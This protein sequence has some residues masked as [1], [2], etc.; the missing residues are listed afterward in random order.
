MNCLTCSSSMCGLIQWDFF[1][2]TTYTIFPPTHLPSGTSNLV[3]PKM[4]LVFQFPRVSCVLYS[5]F[6]V[7]VPS[8]PGSKPLTPLCAPLVSEAR[9]LPSLSYFQGTHPHHHRAWVQ[10]PSASPWACCNDLV[11]YHINLLSFPSNPSHTL[12]L[13]D[14]VLVFNLRI[15]LTL[16]QLQLADSSYLRCGPLNEILSRNSSMSIR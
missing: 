2:P 16:A 5:L 9:R 3:F 13:P 10:G 11:S 15:H 12:R 14:S 1:F 7:T 4:K 6:Q 8:F